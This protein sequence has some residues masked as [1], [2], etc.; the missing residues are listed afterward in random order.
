MENLT[1]AYS[2]SIFY[3]LFDPL[4]RPEVFPDMPESAIADV[5]ASFYNL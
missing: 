1:C 2:R 4:L 3:S 5:L